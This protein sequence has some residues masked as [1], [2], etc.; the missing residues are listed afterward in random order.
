MML[1]MIKAPSAPSN[2]P[3]AIAPSAKRKARRFATMS[4]LDLKYLPRNDSNSSSYATYS[5]EMYCFHVFEQE[6]IV[7]PKAKW[8]SLTFKDDKASKTSFL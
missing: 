5:Q 7:A 2:I 4:K 3:G 6:G 1:F 8:A